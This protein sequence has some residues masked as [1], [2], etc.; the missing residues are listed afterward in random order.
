MRF[1]FGRPLGFGGLRYGVRG[2]GFRV[3]GLGFRLKPGVGRCEQPLAKGLGFGVLG[4]GFRVLGL[5]LAFSW[6]AK[7]DIALIRHGNA[8]LEIPNPNP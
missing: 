7:L 5:D 2:L 6:H 3:W 4:L 1:N 8:W